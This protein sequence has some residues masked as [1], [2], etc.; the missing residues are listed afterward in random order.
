MKKRFP[1]LSLPEGV[2][3]AVV[4]ASQL[5]G[6]RIHPE[7]ERILHESAA[8]S[9]KLQ[10]TLGRL[11]ARQALQEARLPQ[12][13]VLKDQHGYPIWPSQVCGSI[14]H[15]HTLAI[16]IIS[17][18]KDVQSVGA[19]VERLDRELVHDI[20]ARI[21]TPAEQQYAQSSESLLRVFSAKEAIYKALHPIYHRFIG[22]QGATLTPDSDN[23]FKAELSANLEVQPHHRTLAVYSIVDSGH[24]LS[25]VLVPHRS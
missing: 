9:R 5:H 3:A 12:T 16:A 15:A 24:V 22:F 19:D 14:S 25:Y 2:Y 11:A 13:P 21:C 8:P 18:R 20:A 10:F 6:Q 23:G 7:E 17:T 4:E 1:Q